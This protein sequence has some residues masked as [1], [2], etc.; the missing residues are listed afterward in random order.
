MSLWTPLNTLLEVDDPRT[1][2]QCGTC[3]GASVADGRCEECSGIGLV[4]EPWTC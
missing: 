1:C 4:P 2:V 3:Q